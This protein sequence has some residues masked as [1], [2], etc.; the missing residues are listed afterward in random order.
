MYDKETW[1]C[2]A[3]DWHDYTTSQEQDI[4]F[5]IKSLQGLK[6]LPPS[7]HYYGNIEC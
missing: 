1:T 2:V 3:A 4:S 6:L 5:C 7:L